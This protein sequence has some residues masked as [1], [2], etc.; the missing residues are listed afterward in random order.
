MLATSPAILGATEAA[1]DAGS[2]RPSINNTVM[3]T[4]AE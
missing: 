3:G 1:D 2:Y 4:I